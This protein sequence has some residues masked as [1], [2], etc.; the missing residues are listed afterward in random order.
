MYPVPPWLNHQGPDFSR[1][2]MEFSRS[3]RVEHGSP[4]AELFEA[5][6]AG[7]WKGEIPEGLVEAV[8]Q[9]P[10]D[11]L[12]WA[13]ADK[14]WQFLA[15]CL[16][17]AEWRANEGHPIRVPVS[18][19]GSNNGLQLYALLMGD[20]KLARATNVSPGPKSDLY[21]AVADKVWAKVQRDPSDLARQWR[22]FLPDGLPRSAVKRPVMAAPYGIRKHSAASYLREWLLSRQRSLGVRPW[23]HGTFKPCNYL[24]DLVWKEMWAMIEPAET[25]MKWL[26]QVA[27]ACG[28]VRWTNPVGFPIRQDYP[29]RVGTKVKV[30]I[31]DVPK[32]VGAMRGVYGLRTLEATSKPKQRDG[33]PPNYVH[34]LDSAALVATM[35]R[36]AENGIEDFAMVH[37]SYGCPAGDAVRLGQTLR[38]VFAE[39][40][41]EPLLRQFAQEAAYYAPGADIPEPPEHRGLD[42]SVVLESKYFFA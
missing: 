9:D 37:D 8:H 35:N 5:Y 42:A 18:A 21:Q 38:E 13:D 23:G 12:A 2:L 17:A 32:T 34:S 28:V 40:F 29:K 26:R 15:W 36:A 41:S 4:E 16:D 20:H 19:D 24:N 30:V 31:S 6:G 11:C 22:A 25:C 33:L 1:G 7:L 14:P 39:M 10:L 27:N 3:S